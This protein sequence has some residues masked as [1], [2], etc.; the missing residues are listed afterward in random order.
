MK[1]RCSIVYSGY[2]FVAFPV[3]LQRLRFFYCISMTH[4]IILYAASF[5]LDLSRGQDLC[6]ASCPKTHQNRRFFSAHRALSRDAKVASLG[7]AAQ[8]TSIPICLQIQDG[9]PEL[10]LRFC[11]QNWS[12]LD[13]TVLMAVCGGARFSSTAKDPTIF[14]MWNRI[15][16][17]PGC[18]MQATALAPLL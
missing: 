7:R 4:S 6:H 16:S 13:R 1:G 11:G 18:V 9:N 14:Q 3:C 15:C 5:T 2:F 10:G 17:G 8:G 12:V